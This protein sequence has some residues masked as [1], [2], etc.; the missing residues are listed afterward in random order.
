MAERIRLWGFRLLLGKLV[1]FGNIFLQSLF[2]VGSDGTV[3]TPDDDGYF[4]SYDMS[5]DVESIV[6]GDSSKPPATGTLET[7]TSNVGGN[8]PYAL[9]STNR[10][11]AQT[12]HH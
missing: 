12:H 1:F 3:A 10:A 11:P 6:S 8:S 4:D 7:V 5:Q 2:L 9:A